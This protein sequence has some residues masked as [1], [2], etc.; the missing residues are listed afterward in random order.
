MVMHQLTALGDH[1]I[2]AISKDGFCWLWCFYRTL[3]W[4]FILVLLRD[5]SVDVHLLALD[6]ALH[7]CNSELWH[8]LCWKTTRLF[9]LTL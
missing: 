5:H 7:Q 4:G 3:A 1:T 6:A 9:S 2:N 8:F